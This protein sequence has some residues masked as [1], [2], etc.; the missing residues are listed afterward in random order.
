MSHVDGY[1]FPCT[2][3]SASAAAQAQQ[4]AAAVKG[5]K[6]GMLWVDVEIYKWSSNL[7]TNRDFITAMGNELTVCLLLYFKQ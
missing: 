1:I 6:Y 2:T 7:Q 4:A 3:C 5:V